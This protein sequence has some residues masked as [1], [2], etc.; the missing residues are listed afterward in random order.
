[1]WNATVPSRF[2]DDLPEAHVEIAEAP[3]GYGSYG[4]SR[5]DKMGSFQ[6]AYSTPGWQR[7]QSSGQT[8]RQTGS[9]GGGSA[10]H[11]TQ[12]RSGQSAPRMSQPA[13]IDGEVVSRSGGPTSG[14][15]LGNRIFHVKFGNGTVDSVDGNKLTI[16]FDKAGRK[17]VL[18]SF[19]KAI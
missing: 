10:Y 6:S 9:Y 19:V 17:M 4:S 13:Q 5:F 11:A 15:A 7:A 16:N 18:E 12:A 8:S 14:F 2:I 1:M 3:A